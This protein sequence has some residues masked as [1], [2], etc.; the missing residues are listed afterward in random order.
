MY[1]LYVGYICKLQYFHG[2]NCH[3]VHIFLKLH[4]YTGLY[5]TQITINDLNGYDYPVLFNLDYF[6]HCIRLILY[7]KV[8]L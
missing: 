8:K 3:G 5:I 1:T 6:R 4:M 2:K 7:L